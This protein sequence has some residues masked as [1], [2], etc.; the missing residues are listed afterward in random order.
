MISPR[1]R[2]GYSFRTAYGKIDDVA[3]RLAEVG[4]DCLPITD[5]ASTFGFNR[6]RKIAKDKGMRPIYGVELAVCENPQAKKPTVDYW[7]FIPKTDI[8]AI[9]KLVEIA[10]SQF[11]YEPLL[12]YNQALK[13]EGCWK[14]AG[15]RCQI[16]Q[17]QGGS[18]AGVYMGLGPSSPKGLIRGWLGLSGAL[19][20]VSDNYYPTPDDKGLYEIV[21]GRNS[22]DQSYDQHIQTEDEWRESVYKFGL[23]QAQIEEAIE[24][25]RAIM[26]DQQV[27][28]GKA[29]LPTPPRPDT[30]ESMCR[31]AAPELGIDLTD[32]VYE[33][34]LM[35]EIN[36]ITE[37]GYEDYFYIVLDICQWARERMAVGPARGSSCGSLVC[38]LLKITT[39]DPIPHGLIFERFIDINR[40]DMPDIDIDFSDQNR[41]LVFD[42][43]RQKYGADH[44]ARI[45]SVSMYHPRSILTEAGAALRVPKWMCDN[46]AD[47]IIVRSSGDSRALDTLGDT[48]KEMPAGKTLLEKYP[49]FIS[50]TPIEG[51]PRHY[52]QHA[53]GVVISDR[54]IT[55]I[56]AIDNRSGAAMCDKKDAED[57]YNL[58]KVDCLGLTQLST[59][60]DTLEAVGLERDF[61]EKLP[62]DDKDAFEVLNKQQWS[63]IFQFNGIALQ[64]LAKQTKI[65]C[66]EDIVAITALARPGPLTSGGASDWVYRKNGWD[67]RIN[68]PAK[69]TF[70]HPLFE[71]YLKDT[72]GVVMFQEQ[73][74]EIGREIGDLTW[75]DVTLLRKAMSK[76]LG[77]EYF[78]Q[79]GDRWKEAAEAKGI[80]REVLE[81]VW[82]DL[83]AYGAWAFNKSHSVAYGLI[84]YWC[85]YLK[86]HH[87]FEFS[88]ATLTHVTDPE[89]QIALLREMQAE[90]IEY[91]PVDKDLSVDRWIAGKGKGN[92]KV[93]VGPLTNVK[94]IG[95]K[96]VQQVMS[97]K[98]RNEP[99]P[100]RVLKLLE[101][102]VTKIDSIYPITDRV[103]DLM[104]DPAERNIHTPITRIIDITED[105]QEDTTFVIVGVA[106]LIN[107][108]DEN[109]PIQVAKRGYKITRGPLDSLNIQMEDDT[110]IIY[111][112]VNRWKYEALG[113]PI[114]DRGRA[115]KSIY[116]IKGNAMAKRRFLM[117]EMVKYIGDMEQ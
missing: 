30:L 48:L 73:V 99:M 66:F 15:P 86:A 37:K 41:E 3:D 16:D 78:D 38:Y 49:E 31:A 93:L 17:L 75:E 81:K 40:N 97:A 27:E 100:D 70:P 105:H 112:K 44:V 29:E 5:R 98:A 77:K 102:P 55:N 82:D 24:N 45:G 83:C 50:V 23:D 76:S 43:I 117:V 79:F 28:I 7:T 108:R 114:V 35:K 104:P 96:L 109:E 72:Y 107:P 85:C 65:T 116:A 34:R 71:P 52:S 11:R 13:A 32:P 2:T 22:R 89:K 46:V 84:S 26:N 110:G 90:G 19:C 36:L 10:T 87:P 60:E 101:K 18:L 103:K 53:A 88:A 95:P 33:E 4:Y 58:L 12:S 20:S 57:D 1:I 51:H 8:S 92:S 64:S 80:D 54:P 21:M 39:V 69:T 25:S 63:G 113:K 68:K 14:I 74:M 106:R 94:G 115:G 91:V 42:Y 111:C 6:W 56:V 62:L 59:L 47:T 67:P 9:N 61:L